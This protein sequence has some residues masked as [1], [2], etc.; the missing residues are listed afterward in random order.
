MILKWSK[1]TVQAY[2]YMY[3][4]H[5]RVFTGFSLH[6][7]ARECENNT[8]ARIIVGVVECMFSFSLYTMK[9]TVPVD[10]M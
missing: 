3:A 6:K 7:H 8:K 5:A 1:P 4:R 10:F 2:L 9:H